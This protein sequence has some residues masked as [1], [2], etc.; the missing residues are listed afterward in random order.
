[1]ITKFL[2]SL[3][4]LCTGNGGS[5][6][7]QMLVSTYMKYIVS[8]PKV[9]VIIAKGFGCVQTST[10]QMTVIFIIYKSNINSK[11]SR[12]YHIVRFVRV[13]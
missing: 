10:E 4:S 3:L 13:P 11:V 12:M 6:Y 2:N 8:H 5:K 9:T 1:M 7:L